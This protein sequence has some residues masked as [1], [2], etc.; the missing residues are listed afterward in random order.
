MR[1]IR[2]LLVA[3]LM[4]VV[5]ACGGGGTLGTSSTPEAPKYD[6]SI[7]LLNAT[8]TPSNQLSA[9]SPLTVEVAMTSSNGGVV[10]DKLLSFE[11]SNNAVASFSNGT[12]TA[13]TNSSGIAKIT[14]LVGQVSGSANL[15]VRLPDNTLK[16]IPFESAGTAPV[17]YNAVVKLLDAV[18]A[19]SNKLST[20]TPLTV[21]LKLNAST[22]GFNVGKLI[23]FELSDPAIAVFSNGASSA[24]TN[25]D[26]VATVKLLAGTKSGA[27][28]IIATLPDDTKTSKAFEAVGTVPVSF[29]ATI[30][31]LNASGVE[32]T[33]LSQAVPVT[34]EL[35]LTSSNGG[36]LSGQIIK[37]ALNDPAVAQFDNATASAVTDSKGIARIGLTVGTKSGAAELTAT[38]PDTTLAKKA[39]ISAGD[40]PAADQLSLVLSILAADGTVVNSV[41]K[42]KPVKLRAELKSKLGLNVSNRQIN[43]SLNLTDL[44][45]FG[46]TAGTAQTNS[47]GIAEIAMTAGTASGTGTVT[48]ALNG[49]PLVSQ[50]K[51]FDSAGDGGAITTDPVSSVL[52]QSDKLQIG[53]GAVD[54]VELTAIVRDRQLN[55]L[56]DVSVVF[57]VE[58]GSDGEVEVVSGVTNSTG[59]AKAILTTKS[60]PALRDILMSATAGAAGAKSYL[61][62]KVVGTDIEITTVPAVVLGNS[63]DMTFS[64]LDS[65]G[66]PIKDTP[67]SLVSDLKNTFSNTSPRTDAATGRATVRYTAVNSGVDTIRVSALGVLKTA[68]IEVNAD[69][70]SYVKPAN[71][72][73]I[74]EIALSTSASAVVKWTRSGSAMSGQDVGFS[75]TRGAIAADVAGLSAN[76][77][78]ATVQTNASGDAQI[79]MQSAFAGLANIS[80]NT[81]GTG[82]TLQAQ[83]LVEFI[84]VTPDATRPLEVQAIPAQISPGEKSLV[85]AIVRD[86][87]NNPVKNKD[88]AFSL[89]DAFGGQ[90]NP[91]I[92]RTNSQGIASTEFT[93]DATTGGSGTPQDPK[94]LKVKASLVENDAISGTTPIS[95]GNRTLFFRFATGNALEQSADKLLYKWKYAVLVTD[96]SG[97]PVPNQTLTVAVLPKRYNKGAWFKRPTF[98]TFVN[99][100]AR[101]STAAND[102]TCLSEDKNRNGILDAGEDVNNDKTLTPGN[103]T[104]VEKTINS[105]ADGIAYF[106]LTYA[107]EMAPFVEVDIVVSGAAAGTENVSSRAVVLA[108]SGDDAKD[109]AIKPWNSPFGVH[110]SFNEFDFTTT[111][112]CSIGG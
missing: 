76:K 54:K 42:D 28:N 34:A 11:L 66:K 8:G 91:S 98:G 96:S 48:A 110:A 67:L 70:F 26:G 68:K 44:A 17:T 25:A 60:N 95:V 81:R 82:A 64:V 20:T 15:S 79:F 105:G 75:T 62:I 4:S 74:P 83:K 58:T 36:S 23:K 87:N 112:I 12:A 33:T 72:A 45:R 46:N 57:G 43:F 84:A 18:G 24:V 94:G 99:W 52:L 29:G 85:Q 61:T 109:Q 53:T 50:S 73:E 32:V 51:T 49:S 77:V 69:A 21:E 92:A 108:Y 10:S 93:A 13:I 40:N 27:A 104:A 14:L 71:E 6:A 80:A 56:K 5:V 88:I 2:Q 63:I 30:K 7:K 16:T 65:A 41:S 89:I 35:T 38:L 101:Y 31:L 103:V 100:E 59:V 55:L 111:A 1:N 78:V 37:F 39:F 19:E 102:L 22:A 9:Q 106:T 3:F 86:V 90:L 107:K 97:N 47:S